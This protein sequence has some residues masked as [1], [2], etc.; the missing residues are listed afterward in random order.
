MKD[1]FL[2]ECLAEEKQQRIKQFR[3]DDKRIHKLVDAWKNDGLDKLQLE[4]SK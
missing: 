1:T 4:K 2:D 3:E